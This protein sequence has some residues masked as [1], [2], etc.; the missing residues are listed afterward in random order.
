[1]SELKELTI[2]PSQDYNILEK[3]K[4]ILANSLGVSSSKIDI[5]A[6]FIEMGVDSLLLLQISNAIQEQLGV[7]VPFRLLLED[8]PTISALT[9]YIEQ[10]RSPILQ[11]T[12]TQTPQTIQNPPETILEKDETIVAG[13]A[14][15]QLMA[16]QLQLMSKQLEILRKVGSSKKTL[17]S[18]KNLQN[19]Q[20][21]QV[22]NNPSI[23]PAP[24]HPRFSPVKGEVPSQ[25]TEKDSAT[26]L[27]SR[28][29]KHLNDLI[30]RFSKRT[31]ESKRLTQ[32]HRSCHANS[33]AITGFFPS[34][35]EILYPIHAQRG[36]G[37]RL[38]DVDGN[39]YVD[40]SMGFGTLLFG[41][42][43]SFVIEAIQEHIKQGIQH[44]PQ[45]RLSGQVAELICELT[46]A[47]RAAFCNDGT[48]AVMAAIRIARAATGRT[49]IA[50]FAGSYHGTYDG[51]LVRGIAN[52]NGKLRSIPGAL[53][54]PNYMAEDALVLNYGAAE[55]LDILKSYAHE[56]AAILV[57]PV[58]SSRP[59]LQPKEFLHKLRQL[60][61][62]TGIVFILDEVITGFRM[63]PGGIQAL[64]NIQADITTYGKAV[65]SGLPLGVVAGKAA[66]MDLIDGGFW[67]YGDASYPQGETTVFAGTF[68][69]NPLG[70]AVANAVLSHIKNNGSKLQ[71]KL[72][73]RTTK[74]AETL[75]NYFLEK[76]VP[77]RVINFGSLFRFTSSVNLQFSNLFFYHLLEKGV[78]VWE[79]RTLYLSTAHTDE[80]IEKVIKAVKESV[81]EMQAGEFL[82]PSPISR[83]PN[84][85][86]PLVAIQPKGN[87]KPLFFVHPIG[88]NVFCYGNLANCL[89]SEQPF[90]GLQ[91]P[92]LYGDIKPFTK[93]EEIATHYIAAL[94]TMQPE[95][96]YFLGGWSM[97]SFVAFEMA[98]QLQSQGHQVALLALLDNAAP[99]TNIVEY[100]E[101]KTLV[102]FTKDIA[103]SAGKDLSALYDRFLQLKS[104]E[105]FNYV[106]EQLQ[107]SKLIPSNLAVEE[108]RLFFEVYKS[109]SQASLNY[110]PK[111]YPDRI[112][113]FRGS[114]SNEGSQYPE[115]PSWGWRKL[116]SQPVEIVTVPGNH[117]TMLAKPHVQVLAEKLQAYLGLY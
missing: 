40:I 30:E 37:A 55:S 59:D 58:Q 31:Q 94:R 71:E 75:N 2:K 70:M 66:F 42:S 43:P 64:W 89:G 53:G 34:I 60:T 4:V 24:L 103:N 14:I 33:R 32:T 73:E 108:F 110:V 21:A 20:P 116:S 90:F 99:N 97:G 13:T 35:K 72:T 81:E 22:L 7:K 115:D 106:F 16:Q 117:Y 48:E 93:I 23:S 38:W 91:S 52:E 74:L 86:P 65:G 62:E 39:E 104:D 69:K 114:E 12:N 111:V 67:S 54:I 85:K 61:K 96:P 107:I 10:E 8:F 80:D 51:V 87:K 63:H 28:Q 112:I 45:S 17:P 5:H 1:M 49:K 102:N 36:E 26:G 84:P 79:G 18:L 78:Y 46:G 57:E 41:H 19:E 92:G 113:F 88:G 76:Q 50:L 15:E 82:P 98:Q 44:G 47:E 27:T 100:D 68:F 77:I 9:K 109:N 11:L 25:R 101:T 3:L 6:R 56:I 29:Q 105:Q 83:S 95:G